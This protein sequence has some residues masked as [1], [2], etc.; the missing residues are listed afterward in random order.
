MQ[1]SAIQFYFDFS[2]PY[3]YIASEWIEALAARHGRTVQWNAIL[4]GVTFK[5][6]ELK[7]PVDYPIK[8]EYALRD[9]ERSARFEGVPLK[10]PEKFPIPTQNAARVFWWLHDKEPA[11]ATQWGRHGL[12]AYF[13]RGVDLSDPARLA[14][15]AAEFGIDPVEAEAVWNDPVW[16]ARL[17]SANDAAIAAG[18]F[19]APFFIVDK[20]PFWGNDR[21][22]QIER[23]LAKGPF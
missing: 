14:E 17:K 7:S 16:K 4:L 18:V 22:A 15:L 2:S 21:R 13:T 20:E 12:R 5:A 10:N 11:T 6:A 8:R 19:G 1:A 3:S 9:F 23:W